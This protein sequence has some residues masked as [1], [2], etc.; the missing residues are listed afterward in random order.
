MIQSGLG[1]EWLCACIAQMQ[2]ITQGNSFTD[3][4]LDHPQPQH[5]CTHY[6][7]TS[8][9]PTH[10]LTRCYTD[11]CVK[12]F[13]LSNF[14]SFFIISLLS[15]LDLL[16]LFTICSPSLHFLCIYLIYQ[17]RHACS[18]RAQ[19]RHFDSLYSTICYIVHCTWTLTTHPDS[20]QPTYVV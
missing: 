2:S 8:T 19:H 18:H 12:S 4:S 14:L 20:R 10:Q 16:N 3:T 9:R 11:A 17:L 6:W 15:F 7:L 13:D 5:T 1:M